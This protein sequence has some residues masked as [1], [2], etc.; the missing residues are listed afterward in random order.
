VERKSEIENIVEAAG[1]HAALTLVTLDGPDYAMS[2]FELFV[3]RGSEVVLRLPLGQCDTYTT[4]NTDGTRQFELAM[5]SG[6]G[7]FYVSD[8]SSKVPGEKEDTEEIAVHF[9]GMVNISPLYEDW[10]FLW[11]NTILS[12]F[13]SILL[14]WHVFRQFAPRMIDVKPPSV[15]NQQISRRFAQS[16]FTSL[17]SFL[18]SPGYEAKTNDKLRCGRWEDGITPSLHVLTEKLLQFN[19]E[20]LKYF[21][22][23]KVFNDRQL[24]NLKEAKADLAK[25]EK[26]GKFWDELASNPNFCQKKVPEQIDLLCDMAD[27]QMSCPSRQPELIATYIRTARNAMAHNRRSLSL[28]ELYLSRTGYKQDILAK[29]VE[30]ISDFLLRIHTEVCGMPKETFEVWRNNAEDRVVDSLASLT[31]SFKVDISV[32]S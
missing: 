2:P 26:G 21:R 5:Q 10:V 29:A 4:G 6:S 31:E 22:G 16:L 20:Y 1:S 3:L 7:A 28:H 8:V 18:L 9:A 30:V 14:D 11:E 12:E 23:N 27:A 24:E 15:V 19:L 32:A 17:D 25:Y 13:E